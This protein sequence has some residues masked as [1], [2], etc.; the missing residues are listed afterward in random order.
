M[1]CKNQQVKILMKVRHKYPLETAAAKAGM[2]RK[3]AKKYLK[4]G[5][6]PSACKR[7][8]EHRTRIDPFANHWPEVSKML[9]DAPELQAKTILYYLIEKYPDA[10][11]EGHLRTLQRRLQDHRASHGKDREIIF[12]QKIL[13]GQSSQSDWTEMNSLS[14][15]ICGQPFEHTLFHCRIGKPLV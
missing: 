15:T 12:R 14:V 2:C 6:L 11:D 5:R 4:L 7:D 10:Y 1:T 8:R 13:P 3:T 9:D